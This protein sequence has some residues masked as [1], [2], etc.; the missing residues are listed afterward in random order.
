MMN[1]EDLSKMID[2]FVREVRII[3]GLDRFR[4]VEMTD[5]VMIDKIDCIC[6][7]SS[8]ARANFW[9]SS[10]RFDR[11]ANILKTKLINRKWTSEIN[12]SMHE[13]VEDHNYIIRESKNRPRSS[14]SLTNSTLCN[15]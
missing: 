14:I 12:S 6:C 1:F 8:F 4:K 11:N 5:N 13:N 7:S 2:N 9:S 10:K 3:I 15:V